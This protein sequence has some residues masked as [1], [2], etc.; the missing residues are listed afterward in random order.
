MQDSGQARHPTARDKGKELIFP[1]DVD[2]LA[3]DE[4]SSSSSPNLSPAKSSRARSR[5]RHSHRLAFSN[6]D[7]GTFRQARR[8]T[9][10]GQ[11]QP[12]EVPG[13]ASVLPTGVMP[14]MPPIYSAFGTGPTLYTPPATTIQSPNDM[15]SSPLG[16]HILDYE[17]PRGF[18]M[19]TF[20]M[21]DGFTDPYNHI[22]HYNQTMTLNA[23]ND[24]LLC[25]VF[26]ASLQSPVLA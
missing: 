23:D 18:V 19:P 14:P 24:L 2:T 8:E 25:K 26:L 13:N 9:G 6:A 4:L 5:Q 11:N 15:L 1:D 21:F 10:R 7:N 22:L 3:D 20:T 16:R 17:P 12:N